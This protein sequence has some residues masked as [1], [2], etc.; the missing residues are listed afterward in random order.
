MKHSVPGQRATTFCAIL[1]GACGLGAAGAEP[2]T[3][4][5]DPAQGEDAAAAELLKKMQNPVASL[6][7]VPIQNNFDFGYGS[8]DAMRYTL[9]VQPV[10]PFSL[11][12]DWNLITRTIVPVIYQEAPYPGLDDEAG[13]GDILQ[14]FF[15][16]PKEPVGG[17]ILGAGPV[18]LYPSATNDALGAEQWA[19][20]P[21]A[22]VLQQQG[23]WTYGALVNHIA[24]FAGDDDRA[25]LSATFLQPFVS[26]SLKTYTSFAV[27]CEATYDW[28]GE[29]WVVPL[30]LSVSQ[31]LK[32][33]GQPVSLQLGGRYYAEKPEG[34]PEWGIRFAVT[35]LFPN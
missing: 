16:S 12:D 7:S 22:V 9:N 18:L 5:A 4:A 11:T 14:S 6:I 10:V 15:V 8:E 26:Y 27:N 34:G 25:R 35:L 1:L 32:I 3:G 31:L 21:S 28:K 23:S 30:N 29:Q 17:W 20:G 24:S 33:G 19:A 13:L 2:E